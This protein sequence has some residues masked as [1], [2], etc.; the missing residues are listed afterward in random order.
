MA[1]PPDVVQRVEQLRRE[2]REHD[3]HYYIEAR[4]VISDLEYDRLVQELEQLE[5]Q[6]PELITP[7]SPTQRIGDAPVEQLRSVTHRVPMLSIDNTYSKEELREYEARTR[8]LLGDEP[9]EWV[10]EPKI[11]GAAAS[12]VYDRGTL[13]LGATRGNGKVGDDVTH[14]VRTIT[15]LPLALHTPSPPP[16][17]EVRGEVYIRNSDLVAIN[18]QQAAKGEPPFANPRNLA[19]GTLRMLDP[20]VA[21]E[22]R[23]RF[24]CHS[25][26]YVEG[27]ELRSHMEFLETARDFG[28]PTTPHTR[29]VDDFAKALEYCDELIERLHEWDYEV[30]GL[31]LKVNRFDQQRRLGAT[32]KSPRWLIA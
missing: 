27:L 7:D 30:D 1:A 23:L 12:I 13:T 24:Y 9:I 20:R 14:V 2:I 16:V 19:A 5:T 6:Y 31:V 29:V 25:F 3:Y 26:G 28:I 11:D 32:S 17:L 15:D 4:P 10:V 22:R 8:K 21:A 18:E